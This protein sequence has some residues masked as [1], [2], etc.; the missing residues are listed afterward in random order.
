MGSGGN[1]VGAEFTKQFEQRRR[2][3][4]NVLFQTFVDELE[5][6]LSGV[7][8]RRSSE[9]TF[10]NS[11]GKEVKVIDSSDLKVLGLV[12]SAL[13][14]NHVNINLIISLGDYFDIVFVA[15]KSSDHFPGR[16]L[17][18]QHPHA[19]RRP[20]QKLPHPQ[21]ERPSHLQGTPDSHQLV[22]N[23]RLVQ[24]FHDC[25]ANGACFV[26]ER[27]VFRKAYCGAINEVSSLILKLAPELRAKF[28]ESTHQ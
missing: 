17:E 24:L 1:S 26:D 25:T 3:E 27:K 15:S 22:E 23:N 7:Q 4:K 16:R 18:L 2:D 19:L 28:T 12:Q 5:G 14:F 11:L 6:I 13:K 21:Q 20:P 10:N 9:R 8:K